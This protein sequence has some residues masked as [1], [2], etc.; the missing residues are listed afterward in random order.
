MIF[1]QLKSLSLNVRIKAGW[2]LGNFT[3]SLLKNEY[4]DLIS[5]DFLRFLI[6]EI[7]WS[8]FLPSSFCSMCQV[9]IKRYFL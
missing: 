1:K 4:V 8:R 6:V 9:L 3:D 2:S 7:F 5:F